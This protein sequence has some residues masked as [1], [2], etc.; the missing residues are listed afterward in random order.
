[1][2]DPPNLA[3]MLLMFMILSE[4]YLD[5]TAKGARLSKKWALV[6]I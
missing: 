6:L 3:P 5:I 2:G 4:H 1:V